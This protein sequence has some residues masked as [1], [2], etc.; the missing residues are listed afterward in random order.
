MKAMVRQIVRYRHAL[1]LPGLGLLCACSTATRPVPVEDRDSARVPPVTAQEPADGR[2]GT[3]T[4]AGQSG[5]RGSDAAE[6]VAGREPMVM[7]LM[8]ES[9]DRLNAGNPESA[10]ESLERALYLRP[11]D[12]WVW[13]R[14]A[15]VRLEQA[16]W[17]QAVSVAE[18]SNSLAQG[19]RALLA[20]NWQ[21]IARARIALGDPAGAEIARQRAQEYA[22]SLAP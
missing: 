1:S 7:A 17:F 15:R 5:P 6:P 16:R 10:A 13:H 22:S 9:D 3:A 8:S 4:A 18:K 2:P 11:K 20:A 21:V 12:G 14:L 19:D